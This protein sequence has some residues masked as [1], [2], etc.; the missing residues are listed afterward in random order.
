[1]PQPF[2]YTQ[3]PEFAGPMTEPGYGAGDG[4][5]LDIQALRQG[6]VRLPQLDPGALADGVYVPVSRTVAPLSPE[7]RERERHQAALSYDAGRE[8]MRAT[9]ENAARSAGANPAIARR[10]ADTLLA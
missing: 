5:A 9:F 4:P 7:Q 8:A 3:Q 6:T 10:T 2:D 1:M